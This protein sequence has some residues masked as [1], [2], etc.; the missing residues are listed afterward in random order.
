MVAESKV[1]GLKRKNYKKEF[2]ALVSRAVGIPCLIREVFCRNKVT[3]IFYHNPKPN[4]FERHVKYYVKHYNIISLNKLVDA[5]YAED[6]SGIPPKSL[7]ITFDDGYKENYQLLNIIQK[8][9]LPVTVFACSGLINT[10]RHLWTVEAKT[11]V[12]I[13]K[14]MKNEDRLTMLHNDFNFHPE[15]EYATRHALN[16]E[17]IEQMKSA[18]VDFQS[19]TVFHS[20][21]TACL[22]DEC[23]QEIFDSKQQ[24][25]TIL[26]GATIHHFSY[27]NGDYTDREIRYLKTAGYRSARTVDCGWNGLNSDPYKLKAYYISDTSSVT[28]ATCETCGIIQYLY[29]LT[30]NS[31]DGKHRTIVRDLI[32]HRR[33][34]SKMKK[35]DKKPIIAVLV[36]SKVSENQIAIFNSLNKLLS[37][38][39]DLHLVVAKAYQSEFTVSAKTHTYASI[40]KPHTISAIIDAYNYFIYAARIR[41]QLLYH[42]CTPKR[43]GLIVALTG[44]LLRIPSIVTMS[45]EALHS[46][47]YRKG[48]RKFSSFVG[49][50][51]SRFAF[52][53]ASRI[54]CLGESLKTQLLKSGIPASKVEVIPQPI[55]TSRFSSPA[56]K[57]K[58]KN[59]INVPRDKTIGLFVGRLT[60][61]KGADKLYSIAAKTIASTDGFFFILVGEGPYRKNFEQLNKKHTRCVGNVPHADIDAYYKAADVTIITSIT[62]GLPNV[63]LESLACGVPVVSSNVGAVSKIVSNICTSVDDYVGYLT[64]KNYKLDPLPAALNENSMKKQYLQLFNDCM[65]PHKKHQLSFASGMGINA[66]APTASP[67]NA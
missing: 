56:D 24:L 53:L 21:L 28:L 25:E 18:G 46:H 12:E 29:H 27:P 47:H 35:E 10:N 23:R 36:G 54:V 32:H 62:E 22:D 7:I 17:E 39:Y 15:H 31:F 38:H 63:V 50:Y 66:G 45:G 11:K 3:I 64:R 51:L 34:K 61:M 43:M 37:Q 8:Y 57:N 1:F 20:I 19:H 6:W 16:K 41:P 42:I 14:R 59:Y 44:K 48:I 4:V 13:L 60:K 2:I 5:I 26:E 9:N 67:K 65:Y 30:L 49:T 33:I 40:S 58:Y 52:L 55:D